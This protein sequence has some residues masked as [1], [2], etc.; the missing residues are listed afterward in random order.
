MFVP[1]RHPQ[2]LQTETTLIHQLGVSHITKIEI[3]TCVRR[4]LS[5][6]LGTIGFFIYPG[7]SQERYHT[8]LKTESFFPSLPF[9]GCVAP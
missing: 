4:E 5:Y 8:N 7:Q 6:K 9:H 3:T 2:G 1:V